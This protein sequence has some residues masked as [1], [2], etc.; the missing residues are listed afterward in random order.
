MSAPTTEAPK[1]KGASRVRGERRVKA[2][3]R[4]YP[5]GLASVRRRADQEGVNVS[6]LLRRLVAYGVE[7]MPPGW[8]PSD[9]S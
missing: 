7:K 5:E 9:E 4:M 3:F 2:D 6:E 8:D 1:R